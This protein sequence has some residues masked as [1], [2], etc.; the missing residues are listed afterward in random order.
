MLR[1]DLAFEYPAELIALERSPNPRVLWAKGSSDPEELSLDQLIHRIPAGDVLVV[2]TTKV[3]RRRIFSGEY[4][5]LFLSCTDPD[6]Q[7]NWKVLF[8]ARALKVGALIDLPGGVQAQLLEKGRPQVLMTNEPLTEQYFEKFGEL[9]LPPYIQKARDE[10]HQR[11]LDN[12]SYQTAWAETPGSLAAP[13]ASFHFQ[14]THIEKLKEKGVQICQ[15]T[16]HVGLGTFLPVIADDLKDH[17]MHA[18]QVSI[19]TDTWTQVLQ[20][21]KA[22]QGVWALGTTVARALES[23]ARGQLPLQN[24]KYHGE[25]QLFMK[26]GEEWLVVNRL[27]TNFHQPESTLLALVASFA[28]LERVK[29]NYQWAIENKFKLFSYGDFSAWIP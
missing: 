14:E 6:Q 21:R 26:P 1:S 22:G 20:K 28:G 12:K 25:T 29:K 11:P 23:C 8:P 17:V 10:R 27:L 7:K 24:N 3:L 13:T 19:P 2:N 9:P 5:I 18:E 16:L 15:L 4:E